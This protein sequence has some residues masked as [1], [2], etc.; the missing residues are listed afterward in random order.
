RLT[1]RANFRFLHGGVI[2]GLLRRA[3]VRHDL[4]R[5]VILFTPES[6]CVRYEPGDPYAFI[7]TL[8]GEARGL[9]SSL[10]SSLEDLGRTTPSGPPPTLGVNFSVEAVDQLPM[11]DL[12]R[13]S[14]AARAAAP[15]TV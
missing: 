14:A 9:A 13:Q 4:P 3:L 1:S 7:V 11:P 15:L 2:Q 8:A 5:G 12:P 6:G 10:R